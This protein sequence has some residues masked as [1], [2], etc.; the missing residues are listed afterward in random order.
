MKIL[1]KTKDKNL[2][3]NTTNQI[4]LETNKNKILIYGSDIKYSLYLKEYFN[5]KD[6]INDLN[7]IVAKKEITKDFFCSILKF[8]SSLS[9]QS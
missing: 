9:K 4:T 5:Y 8:N 7:Q 6:L 1:L 2:F 3:P